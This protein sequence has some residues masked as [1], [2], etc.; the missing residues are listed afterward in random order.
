[1]KLL[2]ENWRGYL[3]EDFALEE[4]KAEDIIKKYPELQKAFDLGIKK[5]QYLGWM[6]KRMGDVPVEDAVEAVN[7]FD[8]AKALLKTKKKNT[9]IYAYKTIQDLEDVVK[10]AGPSRGE[11]E[12]EA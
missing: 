7:A 1:M 3:E 9:D 8:E 4:G 5:P 10:A 12:R 11:K 6:G 2:F